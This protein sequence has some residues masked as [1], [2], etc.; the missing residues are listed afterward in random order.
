VLHTASPFFTPKED[1]VNELLNPAIQGTKNVLQAIKA[2]APQVKHVVITSSFAAILDL[3]KLQEPK[4]TF[5][6]DSW[7]PITY[8]Q[9]VNDLS[10]TYTASKVFAERAFWEFIEQEKPGF[11]GT[12]VNPTWIFGPIVHK[13]DNPKALNTSDAIIYKHL[14]SK[15]SDPAPSTSYSYWVDVR[16]VALAHV[17]AIENPA[18][19]AKRWLVTTG[20]W[21]DQQI[22]DTINRNFPEFEGEI[23]VGNPKSLEENAKEFEEN[24]AKVDTSATIRESG[25]KF[26]DFETCIVDT[27]KSLLELDKQW[28]TL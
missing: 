26:T 27:V 5:T 12:T 13:V 24:N 23:A 21:N 18:A 28:G 16:D 8:E 11:V 6:R 25:I 4:H 20:F 19:A 14:H 9:A 3:N 15:P 17:L 10:L 2:H 1:P 22:L 7:N